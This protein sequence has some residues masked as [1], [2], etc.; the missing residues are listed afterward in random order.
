MMALVVHFDKFD[1]TDDAINA[2]NGE[3]QDISENEW[4][5]AWRKAKAV[6]ME[7]YT[8]YEIT[9]KDTVAPGD[10]KGVR[11]LFGDSRSSAGQSVVAR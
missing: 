3:H 5:T 8:E 2:N 6:V 7:A 10:R 11:N 9:I 1:T 4:D